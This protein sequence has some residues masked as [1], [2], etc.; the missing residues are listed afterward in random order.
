MDVIPQRLL[1]NLPKGWQDQ[2]ADGTVMVAVP[3]AAIR[4]AISQPLNG[5]PLQAA[6]ENARARE[7]RALLA[8]DPTFDP[9]DPDLDR[10]LDEKI[11]ERIDALDA[12]RAKGEGGA[13]LE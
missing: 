12:E 7:L 6:R 5:V 9:R 1:V 3:V 2:P 11:R 10:K 8:S 4:E 13:R